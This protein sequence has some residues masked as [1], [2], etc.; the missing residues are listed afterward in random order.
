MARFY[1]SI[2]GDRGE[3]TR[4]GTPNSGIQAHIRGWHVGVKVYVD[5][6]EYGDDVVSVYRTGGSNNPQAGERIAHFT[7]DSH[8]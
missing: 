1:A 6:D 5:V 7:A 8:A 2:Q 3:A 4:M